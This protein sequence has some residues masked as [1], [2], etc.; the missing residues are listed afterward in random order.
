[1]VE[2]YDSGPLSFSF[3][4]E[5]ASHSPMFYVLPNLRTRVEID[6]YWISFMIEHDIFR[7]H[8]IVYQAKGVM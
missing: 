6:D 5:G 2:A 3:P 8:I 4:T 1:M 7:I